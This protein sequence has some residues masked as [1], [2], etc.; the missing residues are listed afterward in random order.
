[1]ENVKR[2]HSDE[3][4]MLEK[5]RSEDMGEEKLAQLWDSEFGS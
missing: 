3:L 1:M 4:Q 5:N 2:L